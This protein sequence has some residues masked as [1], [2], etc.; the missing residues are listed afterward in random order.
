MNHNRTVNVDRMELL[1]ALQKNRAAHSVELDEVVIDY[2]AKLLND[3]KLLGKTVSKTESLEELQQLHLWFPPA[4][5]S[6]DT[7]YAEIIDMLEM[8]VD[9]TI[10][11]DAQE[12]KAYFKNEWQ[13]RQAFAA[14]AASYKG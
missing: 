3:I 7:E 4:P 14:A 11:L 13:W 8:S 10:S 5:V 12:F 6:H 9:T 1:S 2:K